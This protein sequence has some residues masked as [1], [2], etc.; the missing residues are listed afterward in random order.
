M[1][2]KNT[3]RTNFQDIF[4]L[5]LKEEEPIISEI[6]AERLSLL[7]DYAIRDSWL[8][9]KMHHVLEKNIASLSKKTLCASPIGR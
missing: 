5:D 7:K 2:K 1:W 4:V 9:D 3:Y 8:F 6:R